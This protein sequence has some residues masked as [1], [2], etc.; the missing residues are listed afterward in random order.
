MVSQRWVA[1]WIGIGSNL[2]NPPVQVHQALVALRALPS[3]RFGRA[4]SLYA[5]PPMGPAGQ[6]DY[7]NAVAGVLTQLG[8]R[9]LLAALQAIERSAGRKRGVGPRWGPRVLDL[10]LLTY[11]QRRIDEPGLTVP[12]PGIAERNFVLLPLLEV[13]P[14]LLIPGLAP[15]AELAASIDR[16]SLRQ[17]D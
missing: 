3:T 15:L 2:Q 16:G 14:G 1:A 10:D 4:S 6:P 8:A 11:G 12:H 13:A 7:V 9:E 17:L 5:N